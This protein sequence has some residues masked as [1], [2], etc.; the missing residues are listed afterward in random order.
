ML[1]CEY[2]FHLPCAELFIP[3]VRRAQSCDIELNRLNTIKS[4][5]RAG[6]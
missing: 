6:M 4:N 2:E 3:L 1:T 5:P